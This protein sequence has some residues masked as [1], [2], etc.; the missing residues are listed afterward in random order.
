[1]AQI[2]HLSVPQATP[3]LWLHWPN[4]V[5]T[6]VPVIYYLQMNAKLMLKQG[7]GIGLSTSKT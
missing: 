6:P 4:G 5:S 1:M 3:G 2:L 7:T